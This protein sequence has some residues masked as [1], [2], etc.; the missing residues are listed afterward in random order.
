MSLP[1]FEALGRHVFQKPLTNG[2]NV[3][4][5][6]HVLSIN[7]YITDGVA[8]AAIIAKLMNQHAKDFTDG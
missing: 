3:T 5:G 2:Q 4:I 8:V 1:V 6:F 7:E